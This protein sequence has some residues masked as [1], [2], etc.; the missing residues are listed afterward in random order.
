[1]K[2]YLTFF[3]TLFVISSSFGSH[4]NTI[5]GTW[6][7]EYY[8]I[9]IEVDVVR[10]GIRVVRLDKNIPYYYTEAGRHRFIDG[11]GNQYRI[12]GDRLIF[13]SN[14]RRNQLIFRPTTTYRQ[15]YHRYS[16]HRHHQV[17]HALANVRGSWY[18]DRY[19][20]ATRIEIRGQHAR[21]KFH[22]HWNKYEV[23]DRYNLI[24][25]NGNR[26]EILGNNKILIDHHAYRRPVVFYRAQ[27]RRSYCD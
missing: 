21:V 13:T 17:D 11:Q 4:H 19:G 22:R 12:D 6:H 16:Q 2:N 25:R 3:L 1:M 24:D 8:D 5:S 15:K 26:I 18:N 7:E 9:Y 23:V 20:E 14:N 10:D 27:D